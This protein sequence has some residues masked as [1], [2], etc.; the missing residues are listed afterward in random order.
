MTTRKLTGHIVLAMLLCS[1]TQAAELL[2]TTEENPPFNMMR[3]NKV[4][5]ISS[6]KISEMMKRAQLPYRTETLPWARAY[7]IALDRPH[8]CVFSTT[9]T[10]EREG[11]FKWVGPIAQTAWV[12]YAR[13]DKKFTL[14]T[15]EDARP[16]RIGTYNADVRD[17][18]LK[19]KG[20]KVESARDDQLN[21][22]KLMYDR[23]DLWATGPYEANA[24]LKAY[25]LSDK[26]VPVLAF[27]KAE[28]Y[29]ACN[30]GVADSAI[31]QLNSALKQMNDDGASSAIEQQ[32][33][34]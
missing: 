16:L 15:L 9:R 14:N 4:V 29:L 24:R 11:K 23:I 34:H 33:S 13:A 26:I 25:H 3:N 32:Y 2:L 19:E 28:L 10:A 5:G 21:P 8:A 1:G 17:S 12:F 6:D 30:P 7:Q 31:A 22:F 18:Y 20:F 27:R